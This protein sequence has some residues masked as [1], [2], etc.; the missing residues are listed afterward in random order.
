[1][2]LDYD[3]EFLEDGSTI[4]LISIGIVA[5]DGREY[6]AVNGDLAARGRRGRRLRRQI[7]EHPWLMTH[8][9]P[10]LPKPQGDWNLHM[11]QSWLFDYTSRVVKPR[12]RIAD[13]VAAFITGYGDPQLWADYG[14]YD[15]V[16]L[17]QLW[18]RMI[19]LPAGVPMWTNDL[20]QEVRRLENPQVPEQPVWAEHSALEDA[21][22]NQVVRRFLRDY[23][24]E[25]QR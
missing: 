24:K 9:V 5:D 10:H 4:T 11:P 16:V 23:E 17:C 13:E 12:Q 7:R 8:V 3:C 2:D 22:H 19:D 14:A 6:Y 20:R 15:H 21:R 18:G 1:M 25:G